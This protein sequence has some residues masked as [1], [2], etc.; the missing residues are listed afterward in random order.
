ML[1]LN[2]S[3]AGTDRWIAFRSHFNTESFYCRPGID[4]THERRRRRDD[5]LLPPHPFTPVPEVG[6]LAELNEMIAQWDLHDRRRRVG[7]RPRTVDEYFDIYRK[8]RC[9]S[10]P[11]SSPLAAHRRAAIAGSAI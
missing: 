3:R 7:S 5:R 1:G 2:R 8:P 9:G 11:A 6:S 10:V 4:G